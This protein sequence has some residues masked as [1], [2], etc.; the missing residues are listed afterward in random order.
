MGRPLLSVVVV[1]FEMRRE[2]PRTLHTLSPAYQI[3][4]ALDDYEVV[5]VDNGSTRPF[6]DDLLGRLPGNVR[7]IRLSGASPSPVA[8]IAHGVDDAVGSLWMLPISS[9]ALVD[10]APPTTPP[11][12]R[13]VLDDGTRGVPYMRLALWETPAVFAAIVEQNL[14]ERARPYL[15]PVVRSDMAIGPRGATV[16]T[17]L[18]YLHR[19]P[20]A[21]RFAFVGPTD[22]IAMLTGETNAPSR[23]DVERLAAELAT[24][25]AAL[26]AVESSRSWRYTATARR[27][28]RALGA[29]TNRLLG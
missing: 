22:A 16:R 18:E 21:A 14:A 26:E 9:G 13:A 5:V 12:H 29:L 24:A 3:D 17:N 1:V 20:L 4:I 10:A 2:A 15:A 6:D 25:R 28:R 7:Y 11:W 23:V 8:A 27:L 19:H